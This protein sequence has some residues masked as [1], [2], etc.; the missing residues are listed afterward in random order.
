MSSSLAYLQPRHALRP[1]A[2]HIVYLRT[3]PRDMPQKLVDRLPW[4]LDL[5]LQGDMTVTEAA[6]AYGRQAAGSAGRPRRFPSFADY[7]ADRIRYAE[8]EAVADQLRALLMRSMQAGCRGQAQS[9]ATVRVNRMLAET[10]KDRANRL[11]ALLAE[12]TTTTS[13]A[14]AII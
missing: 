7:I 3:T 13:G 9:A 11:R 5:V 6:E 2:M 14:T 4:W 1:D 12:L 8:D 10:G